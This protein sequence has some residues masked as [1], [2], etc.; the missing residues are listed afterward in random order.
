MTKSRIMAER[1]KRKIVGKPRGFVYR[2][3]HKNIRKTCLCSIIPFLRAHRASILIQSTNECYE[4]IVI[5]SK[6]FHFLRS[7]YVN[8]V[9]VLTFRR[10]ATDN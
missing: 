8:D 1:D 6:S 9:R 10:V 4:Y 3:I 5:L 2:I 7:T